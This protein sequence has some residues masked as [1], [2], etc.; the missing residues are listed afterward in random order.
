MRSESPSSVW[1]V[2]SS[3]GDGTDPPV[4]SPDA[5]VLAIDVGGTTIKGEITDAARTV[6]AAETTATPYGEAALDAVRA[7]GDSLLDSLADEARARVERGAVLLPGVV[8]THRSVAVRSGNLGWRD[9][10]IGSRFAD[11]WSMPVLLEHDVTV[12]GW[13]EWR[14]GAGRDRGTVCVVVIGT[15]ISGTLAVDGRLVRGG[16]G[17]A[18]EYGHITVRADGLRC[19]CGNVGCVETVASAAAIARAYAVRA[20]VECQSAATVFDR[21]PVDPVAR[22]VVAEAVDALADGLLGVVHAACP[23]VIVL[24]GGLAGA[25]EVLAQE[26]RRA[27]GERVR[28]APVPEVVIGAFGARAGLTGAALFARHGGLI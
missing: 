19:V 24:G 23:E 4:L 20:S 6:L 10:A 28:V 11:G 17:Q 25:G 21:M 13:A 7:V 18:G 14:F 16:I 8:D 1:S 3:A 15:G 12:G 5:L 22:A 26:L 2:S 27:L 9:V